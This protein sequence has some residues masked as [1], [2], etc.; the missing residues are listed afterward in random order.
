MHGA[1]ASSLGSAIEDRKEKTKARSPAIAEGKELRMA[2]PGSIG[3][4]IGPW[5]WPSWA[6]TA[7]TMITTIAMKLNA[8]DETWNAIILTS[9]YE[10]TNGNA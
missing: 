5:L 2:L 7:A 4:A 8:A 6:A 9:I 10:N 3:A 1:N